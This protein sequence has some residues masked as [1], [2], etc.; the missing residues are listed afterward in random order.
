MD[1]I[2]LLEELY[3]YFEYY[4]GEVQTKYFFNI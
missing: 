1:L 4:S 3:K 2:A